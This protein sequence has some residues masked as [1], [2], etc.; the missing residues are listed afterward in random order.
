MPYTEYME[1]LRR[2]KLGT[3]KE[4]YFGSCM[5]DNHENS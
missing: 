3:E 5:S 1:V 2:C 4:T